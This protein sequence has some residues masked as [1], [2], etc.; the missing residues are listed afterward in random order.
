MLARESGACAPA[1]IGGALKEIVSSFLHEK[2]FRR[3]EV[4]KAALRNFTCL[5]TR[6]QLNPSSL[7]P[8]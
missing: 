1:S 4:G 2:T 3:P 6:V 5:I 8:S 7:Y